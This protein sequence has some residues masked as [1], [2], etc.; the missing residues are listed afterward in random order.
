[1]C[2][3]TTSKHL[4]IINVFYVLC[5]IK[6]P[7]VA[8]GQCKG[9]IIHAMKMRVQLRVRA[10]KHSICSLPLATNA[11]RENLTWTSNPLTRK[12]T[13][14][15]RVQC[16][17]TCSISDKQIHFL[18]A[19]IKQHRIDGSFFYFWQMLSPQSPLTSRLCSCHPRLSLYPTRWPPS[20]RALTPDVQFQCRL[21]DQ[22]G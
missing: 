11:Q 10:I 13:N 15:L 19:Y 5:N 6:F 7:A 1:M 4:R 18:C 3:S 21:R 12:R 20:N 8:M 22:L 14:A 16:C 9:S 17:C 2:C